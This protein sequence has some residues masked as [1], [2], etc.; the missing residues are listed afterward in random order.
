LARLARYTVVSNEGAVVRY[1]EKNEITLH[2][3][4]MGVSRHL[5]RH[6]MEFFAVM[7]VRLCRQLSGLCLT[8]TRVRFV[9]RRKA[10]CS[11]FVDFFGS[12]VGFGAASDQMVFPGSI[13]EMPLASADPYLHDLVVKSL[14]EVLAQRGARRGSFR[15]GVENELVAL[16]PHGRPRA[17][18]IARRLG[19]SRRTFARRLA[20]EGVSFSEILEHLR[21]DL[22]KRHLADRDL[23]ISEIAWLL[24]YQEVSAFTHAFK[25]WTGMTP[26][27]ARRE[28]IHKPVVGAPI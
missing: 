13:G 5:D 15:S 7:L 21:C 22:A 8:P 17:E 4:Y 1:S 2:M 26:R 10:V 18:E 20:M 3:R 14:D 12:D 24:G 16:L 23:S 25:R 6:Q 9:H 27:G 28:H 11:A 19:T